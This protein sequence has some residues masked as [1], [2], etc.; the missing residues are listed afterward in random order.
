MLKHLTVINVNTFLLPGIKTF[1]KAVSSFVFKGRN[2]PS[3]TV[4]ESTGSE[5]TNFIQKGKN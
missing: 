3:Q 1:L 5:C 2:L 4:R